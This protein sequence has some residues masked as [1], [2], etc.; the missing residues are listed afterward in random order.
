MPRTRRGLG[1]SPFQF[2]RGRERH[3]FQGLAKQGKHFFLRHALLNLHEGTFGKAGGVSRRVS[4]GGNRTR[5]CV[6]ESVA[7]PHRRP[8]E[9]DQ[10]RKKT[11]DENDLWCPALFHDGQFAGLLPLKPTIPAWTFMFLCR[12]LVEDDFV[13][14]GLLWGF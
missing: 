14:T 3:S 1:I 5:K 12:F 2:R 11:C 7:L 9:A 13:N 4:S 8:C 10:Q 6:L